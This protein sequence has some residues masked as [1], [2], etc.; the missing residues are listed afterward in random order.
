MKI[1]T[2]SDLKYAVGR[3]G[4]E[5]HFFS[6]KTMRFFGDTMRNY[7]V[8]GPSAVQ[9]MHGPVWA[10]ELY[11]RRPV[12]HGLHKSAFFCA[13][14]FRRVFPTP[15]PLQALRHHVTCAIERGEAVAI[16]EQ[17]A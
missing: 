12:K 14:T 5:P 6:R 7:G 10:Y 13:S 11:R 3:S 4:Q 1:K 16:T 9:T 2:S 15:P 17:T 8:R